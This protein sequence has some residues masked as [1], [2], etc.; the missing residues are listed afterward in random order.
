M[1]RML[2]QMPECMYHLAHV[3]E[4]RCSVQCMQGLGS[5]RA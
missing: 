2:A 3:E 1:T 5:P 4:H